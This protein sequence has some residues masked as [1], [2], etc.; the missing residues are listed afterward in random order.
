MSRSVTRF[1]APKDDFSRSVI[2]FIAALIIGA[3]VPRTLGFLIRKVLLRSFR[4]AFILVAAGWLTDRLA[5]F[6]TSSS[7]NPTNQQS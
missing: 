7:R 5:V 3:L 6:L 2:G 4:E 1:R